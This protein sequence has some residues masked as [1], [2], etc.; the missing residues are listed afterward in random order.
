MPAP[1]VSDLNFVRQAYCSWSVEKRSPFPRPRKTD[2]E[3]GAGESFFLMEASISGTDACGD[4][5]SDR[6]RIQGRDDDRDGCARS[7]P[8]TRSPETPGGRHRRG[9]IH[10]GRRRR[11]PRSPPETQTGSPSKEGP[12]R[13]QRLFSCRRYCGDRGDLA[14]CSLGVISRVKRRVLSLV[15]D[16]KNSKVIAWGFTYLDYNLMI[17]KKIIWSDPV[18]SPRSL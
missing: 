3:S 15:F 13:P 6:M 8:S 14:P 10:G 1:R 17:I 16:P 11:Y 18:P 5:A 4:R 9:R 2:T 7:C 12:G